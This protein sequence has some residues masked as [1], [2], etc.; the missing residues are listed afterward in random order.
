MTKKK[1]TKKKATQSSAKDT[2]TDALK[3][4]LAAGKG[5]K[6]D[7]KTHTVTAGDMIVKGLNPKQ[8][9][10]VRAT[11]GP[12][13][14]LAGAGS[15]KTKTLIHRIAY[16][17]AHE[18]VKP[19]NILAVTFT[20]KAAKNMQER[21]VNLLGELE[22]SPTMGTFHS[23]CA[24]LLRR[25]I[26]A[27]G[28]GT[29]FTIYDSSDQ[30]SL[31]KKIMKQE[32]YDTKQVSPSGVHWRI[33]GAKNNLVTP[34][35][36]ENQVDDAM[37]EVAAIVYPRYQE[38]LQRANALDFDDLIMKTVE[39]LEKDPA[40][41]EKYQN[42]WSHI[43][44]DEYQD[45]NLSQYKL[46][47]MLAEKNKNL[48]VVGDDAQCVTPSTK[49]KTPTGWKKAKDVKKG[50]TILAAAGRGDVVE[51]KVHRVST[52]KATG[53]LIT[54][55]TASGKKLT[56]TP[57][58]MMFARIS[59]TSSQNYVYL[60]YKEKM[61]YRIG[62]AKGVRHPRA[63]STQHGLIVRSNQEKADKVWILK[64]CSSKKD[65]LYWE[66]YYSFAYGIPTTV[67]NATPLK[68]VD[69]EQVN[70][71]FSSI[72][73]HERVLE[74]CSDLDLSLE[75]PH[76]R[77]SGTT[78]YS[79]E[80]KVLRVDWFAD[81]RATKE[82]KHHSNRIAFHTTNIELRKRLESHGYKTRQSKKNTWRME[83]SKRS[84]H[85][86]HVAA[87]ELQK[88]LP[89]VEQHRGV[90]ATANKKMLFM[91]AS[92]I[93]TSMIIPVLQ[94]GSIV[95][96]EVVSVE[97]KPYEGD[98]IDFNVED[99][100]N[101][102]AEGIAIHNSIY[103]W[104]AADIRNI[105]NFEQDYPDAV[106]VPLEQN[107]RSTKTILFA[108]NAVIA[109]N[110][111]QKEKELW[112][113]NDHGEKVTVS[114]VASEEKEGEFIVK[115]MMALNGIKVE[116]RAQSVEE[117]EDEVTYEV[118]EDSQPDPDNSPIREGESILD[119]IMGASMFQADKQAEKLRNIVDANRK[120][121]NF[122][123]YVVLYRTNAQSRAIEESFLK[124]NIPYQIIGGMR[125]YDRR[126][127]K[128]VIAY[129]RVV[130]NPNDWVSM[131]RIA[132]VPARGIG[133]KTWFKVEQF[134]NQ[135]GW[136]F[137]TAAKH[138][139]P[140]IQNA[141][142][143]SVSQFAQLL[144]DIRDQLEEMSP[145]QIL[146][147]VLKEIGYKDHLINTSETKDKGESRWENVQELK[148]VSEKFR[149]LRGE[150]GLQA[151][152]EEIALVADQDS[153]DESD[154]AVKLMTIH[155]AKGL[156]FPVVFVVGMEEGLFPHSRSL[157]NP[158]EMEEER[159]LCYVALTRAEKRVYL[160]FASQR[161]RYGKTQVNPPSRFI[162]EI[163]PEHVEWVG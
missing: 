88:I 80:R 95:D 50:D 161:M 26:E 144:R 79:T 53:E 60:M 91:P 138:D 78:R 39:L 99:V 31:V 66:Q 139:I 48:C 69:Q 17:I 157:I 16:L 63:G 97:R 159:R 6:A 135:R 33:S 45:T 149:N 9:E 158:Q 128:D 65:A 148:N 36:F 59:R 133:D 109:N 145:T 27:L 126:E 143:K 62:I 130:M 74:L 89:E 151:L 14:V 123:D 113:D 152:L 132:N 32:G 38:E 44:V 124:Y 103:S 19:W 56:V 110:T 116:G 101:F 67:F 57:H 30:Q 140:D 120:N 22:H 93:H 37:S 76:H 1:T 64:T 52:K 68:T 146:D 75:H 104:R 106:V 163:P 10:A 4:K 18:G 125:F 121:I 119:R 2:S 141:R 21:M 71:L 122:A 7:S 82:E 127:I 43:L 147:L 42:L 160:L 112:T 129:L 85:D 118:D 131:E 102:I 154:N 29:N 40:I 12:V 20:N 5:T 15:G 46:V 72:D 84:I 87:E 108:S 81:E 162:D 49:I 47:S 24:R 23:I 90:W 35:Q 114:E 142:L 150:E 96:D 70:A 86:L 58:H 25:D 92:H 8:E 73:T 115:E 28:Y 55:T 98:V 11:T 51:K 134:A 137:I 105:L 41:L 100:H 155:A 34:S 117:F 61:G 77:T 136:D 107:Y 3:K 153:L 156:E 111:E 83:L 94:N 54:I 13:L